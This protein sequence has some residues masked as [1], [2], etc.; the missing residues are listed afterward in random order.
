MWN[1]AIRVNLPPPQNKKVL[2]QSL[3]SQNHQNTKH[4]PRLDSAHETGSSGPKK[5]RFDSRKRT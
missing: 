3:E 5:E 4:F 2:I 1:G